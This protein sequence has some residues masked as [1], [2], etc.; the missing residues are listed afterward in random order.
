MNRGRRAGRTEIGEDRKL[1]ASVGGQIERR[2]QPPSGSLR[3]F[4]S[5]PLGEAWSIIA[6][7]ACLA[8]HCRIAGHCGRND[9]TNDIPHW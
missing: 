4:R 5:S 6:V 2:E 8:C 7:I 3:N 9:D 1:A